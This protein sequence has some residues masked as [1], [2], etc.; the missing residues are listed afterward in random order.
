M[1]QQER[2]ESNM[3]W[4][5]GKPRKTKKEIEAEGEELPGVIAKAILESDP[6]EPDDTIPS[7][8]TVISWVEEICGSQRFARY[9]MGVHRKVTSFHVYRG[10]PQDMI[11]HFLFYFDT[12]VVWVYNHIFRTAVEASGN[13]DLNDFILKWTPKRA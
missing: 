9:Q 2:K 6:L 3:G 12:P 13:T 7:M 11:A 8:D 5:K 10:S 1:N 4:E